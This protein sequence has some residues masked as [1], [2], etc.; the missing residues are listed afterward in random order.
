MLIGRERECARLDE[1]LDRARVGRSG[2]L[3]IRGEAG[4]GKTAL[5]DYAAMRAADMTVVRAVGVESEAQLEFSGLLEVCWPL[6]DGLVELSDHQG[7]VLRSAL[8][9]GPAQE[10]DRFSVGAA[11]LSLLAACADA[12]PVCVVVDD[13]QWLDL[14]SQDALVFAAKRL[15]ADRVGVIFAARDGED[16]P[17]EAPGLDLLPLTGLGRDAAAELIRLGDGVE[18]A[19]D[20]AER[21]HAATQ[22]NPLALIE[23][24]RLLTSEQLAGTAP[25][26]DPLPTGPAVERAFARRV[27]DL[28]ESSQSALLLAAVT[29]SSEI[30][31]IANGLAP[32]GV[33]ADALE[34]AEDAGLVRLA[35]GQLAFRHP[36]VRSAVYHAAAPSDRRAAHRA[37]A[38]GLVGTTH[39]EARAW[40]LAG[41]ALGQ[42]D[43]A[44]AALEEAADHARRRGG[45]AAAAADLERAARLTLDETSR[46]RRLHAAADASWRAG[47]TE[48]AASLATE[49]LARLGEPRL[50]ATALRLM[51]TIDY[52]RGRA[53]RAAEALGEAVTLLEDTDPDAAVE[54][55]ADAVNA[56][57]RVR[58]REL[59][60]E[61]AKR[62]RALAPENGGATDLEAAIA[63]GYAF[64]F[65]G[66]YGDAKPHLRRAAEL[67]GATGTVSGPLQ[68]GRLSAALGWLG[69]HEQAHAFL[70][71]TVARARAAGAVGALPH[72][73]ASASWQALH[74]TRFNEAYADASEA[75]ELA[76]E[77][78]QPVT[79]AQA[80]GVLTWLHALRGDEARCRT[81]GEETQRRAAE[82]GFTLYGLLVS[83]CFGLLDV[84]RGRV[85]EA[86]GQLES[87]AR[88]A[89]EHDLFVPGVSPQLELA[90]AYS[91]AGRVA[92][93]ETVLAA[94]D[95]SVLAALPEFRA[96]AERCRGLLA[97][98]DAFEGHFITALDLHATGQSPMALARTRL[99]YG[100]RLRR[101]GR[102]VDAREQLR[103]ALEVFDRVG[104][105]PWSERAGAELRASGETLR[106]RE[107]HEAEELTPQELQIALHVAEGK[108]N[109]EVGAALFLSHKTIEF[110]LSRVYRKLD[111][112]SRAELIRLYAS[113]PAA[114]A[115]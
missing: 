76:K 61:T 3:V 47:R 46:L 104:A 26:D 55:A 49:A 93:A 71:A 40:H 29:T 56:L 105:T 22:G 52:F 5:L 65:A 30:E 81:T 100:E 73:L 16:V 50:R 106:R 33:G 101:A 108:S 54:A 69:R 1:L 2:T 42:D 41:A 66:R 34:S 88:H 17:F 24:P 113:E 103:P 64:C 111:I 48:Q 91:R 77:L 25:L 6:R 87:V 43:A 23:L 15:Q 95:R 63:L 86:I 9:I 74:A 8:G 90:E 59:A 38:D 83:L 79:A 84:G 12:D 4:I 35:D 68:A 18:V 114:T 99:C 14:A 11:T 110:H 102:R 28:P 89:D 78:E 39:V 80:L 85:D 97:G 92:D 75:V 21:L 57:V 60:L 32:L 44:A 109:K 51:G 112:H 98:P 115:G 13:A 19:A 10:Q 20:V 45:Y 36:L 70:A 82:F 53:D 96:R 62:A 31:T 72:L 107:A 7:G 94:F 58:Q 67:F 27:L 37:I